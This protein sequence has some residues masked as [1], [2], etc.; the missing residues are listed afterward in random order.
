MKAYY[1]LDRNSF[2]SAPVSTPWF[3]HE[4]DFQTVHWTAILSTL[5]EFKTSFNH[6]VS[7]HTDVEGLATVYLFLY[8]I[9]NIFL[10]VESY[11]LFK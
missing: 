11:K 1:S 8:P 5:P 4:G 6:T 10:T 9:K 7:G 2:F 3:S